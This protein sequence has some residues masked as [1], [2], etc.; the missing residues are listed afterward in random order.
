MIGPID[1]VI[2]PGCSVLSNCV[3]SFHAASTPSGVIGRPRRKVLPLER[4]QRS[5][6]MKPPPTSNRP[7]VSSDD[8]WH[9][10]ATSGDTNSGLS[11]SIRF[12]GSTVSVMREPAIGA[13]VLTRTFFFLPSSARVWAKPWMPSLA[14][15]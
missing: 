1:S 15:E 3:M 2:E 13:I 7:P 14:I 12:C 9:S 4:S 8:S 11:A 5:L 6:P 10:R